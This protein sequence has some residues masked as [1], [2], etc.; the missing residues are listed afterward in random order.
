[1][2]T[3]EINVDRDYGRDE[4]FT[5]EA[6]TLDDVMRDTVRPMQGDADVRRIWV[7][8]WQGRIVVEWA[9]AR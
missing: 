5:V 6:E 8:E 4:T 2:T 7:S 3:F 1:M 9:R